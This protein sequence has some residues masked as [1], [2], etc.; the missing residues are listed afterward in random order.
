MANCEK[1]DG[2]GSYEISINHA[3]ITDDETRRWNE[4]HNTK[5]VH[6]QYEDR[7]GFICDGFHE[8]KCECS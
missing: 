8:I 4:V 1:C 3:R 7:D 6:E 2:K 5:G